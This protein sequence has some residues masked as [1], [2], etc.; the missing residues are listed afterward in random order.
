MLQEVDS[1]NIMFFEATLPDWVTANIGP[2]VLFN[3]VKPLGFTEAPGSSAGKKAGSVN[4][5]SH[6][7][8]YC[9][10]L[11]IDVCKEHDEP[12]PKWG[13][14][15]EEYH[16]K[17]LRRRDKDAENL[18]IPLLMSEFG[19]CMDTE[20]C[21]RE[22]QQV[23][24]ACD[25]HLVG[26]AYWQFKKFKDLTTTAMGSPEGFYNDDGSLQPL[27]VRALTRTYIQRAQG[28]VESMKFNHT[29]GEFEGQFRLNT[30][31]Q[32]FTVVYIAAVVKGVSNYPNGAR[33]DVNGPDG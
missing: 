7:H 6:D 22:I 32:A 27:K 11:S 1:T 13:D 10:T 9:C 17:R 21:A 33:V 8:S 26:W 24:S 2:W 25:E 19:A 29:T 16:K 31:V 15:C 23:T 3:E 14:E 12:G 20:E 4:H 30:N 18:G 28:T 5:V